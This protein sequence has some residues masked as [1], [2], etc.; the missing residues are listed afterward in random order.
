MRQMRK[1]QPRAVEGAKSVLILKGNKTSSQVS[2]FLSDM[3]LLRQGSVYYSK[4]HEIF[5]FEDFGEMSRLVAKTDSSLFL[6]GSSSKKRPGRLVFGRAFDQQL[7]DMVELSLESFVPIKAFE[8]AIPYQVRPLLFFQGE[9]WEA[10]PELAHLR[11]LLLDFFNQNDKTRKLDMQ[12]LGLLH[13]FSS[14]GN[15]VLLRT[16]ALD[17]Q[18]RKITSL[19][20]IDSKLTLLESGPHA[21]FEFVRSKEADKETWKKAHEVPAVLRPT[22]KNISSDAIGNKQGRVFVDRQDLTQLPV[23]KRKEL[24]QMLKQIESNEEIME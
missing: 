7:L 18:V 1:R 21:D 12:E 16:F 23:R 24:K 2:E 8:S 4:H 20:N 10:R 15:R 5:P 22:K 6:F 19:A 17:A 11:M 14:V 3:H 9:E 13:V